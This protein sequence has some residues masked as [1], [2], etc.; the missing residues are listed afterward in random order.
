MI[1]NKVIC[2]TLAGIKG[3][4]GIFSFKKLNKQNPIKTIKE[5]KTAFFTKLFLMYREKK[6]TSNEYSIATYTLT[7]R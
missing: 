7:T 1:I 5:N 4:P 2:S 3:N 6:Y